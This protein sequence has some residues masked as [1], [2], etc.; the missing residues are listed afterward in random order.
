M[1]SLK[2]SSLILIVFLCSSLAMSK[3]FVFRVISIKGTVEIQKGNIGNWEALK[4]ASK[5]ASNDKIRIV[6][7]S[8][9]NLAHSSGKTIPVD[10]PE[11]YTVPQLV[12]LLPSGVGS[13]GSKLARSVLD[14]MSKSEN[15][16][17]KGN[18]KNLTSVTGAG[19]R[20][21]TYIKVKS[22]R[23]VHYL[24]SEIAFTWF[25]TVGIQ[26]YKF[27]ITDINDSPVY[28]FTTKDTNYL[29]DVDSIGIK[30]DL[31]YFWYVASSTEPNK[32][33]DN[34]SFKVLSDNKV[35]ILNDSLEIIKREIN[36]EESAFQQVV[37]AKFYENNFLIPNAALAYQK[38]ISL[39]PE[40]D[41]YRN[42]YKRFVI[43][44]N[45]P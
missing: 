25:K 27:F 36:A 14:D 21:L 44:Y 42:L 26:G 12:A 17:S 16:L 7:K 8:S 18:K 11:E 39:S 6:G 23:K 15:M 13:V 32:K 20:G 33:S 35:S 3:D 34:I 43:N 9:V 37:I 22:P 1:K 40:V 41:E 38:A 19:E 31:Y 2:I 5:I 28:S 45:Y 4:T 30:K 10:T 29:I 24:R